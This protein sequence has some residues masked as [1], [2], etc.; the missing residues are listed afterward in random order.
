MDDTK[1]LENLD[2]EQ[3]IC[4]TCGHKL[5]K[6]YY[7]RQKMSLTRKAYWKKIKELERKV[8]EAEE[9]KTEPA[10]PD[11]VQDVVQDV[12]EPVQDTVELQTHVPL[13][14]PARPYEIAHTVPVTN[15]YGSRDI[16][17]Y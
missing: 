7:T 5:S 15:P 6:T 1:T 10:V 4:E 2:S 3:K 11:V 9:V 12:P 13:N 8:K 14:E 17:F 16:L